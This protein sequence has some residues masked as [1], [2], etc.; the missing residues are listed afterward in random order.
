MSPVAIRGTDT[1]LDAFNPDVNYVA[2]RLA[3]E[4]LPPQT[5]VLIDLAAATLRG[6]KAQGGLDYLCEDGVAVTIRGGSAA[7]LHAQDVGMGPRTWF[8]GLL[9][10]QISAAAI[11]DGMVMIALTQGFAGLSRQAWGRVECECTRQI[12]Q[13]LDVA[14]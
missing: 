12:T 10:L 3:L 13:D 4:I 14:G 7:A 1:P 8:R 6:R 5:G 9:A 11:H 2:L